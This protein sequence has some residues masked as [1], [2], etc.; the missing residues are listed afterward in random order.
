MQYGNIDLGQHWLKKC[1]VA[2]Q[3]QAITMITWTNV[4]LLVSFCDNHHR[5]ISQ[6][7]ITILY[8]HV[9]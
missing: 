7:L 9:P 5:E 1:V 3:H 2:R 6:L 4:D 8:I